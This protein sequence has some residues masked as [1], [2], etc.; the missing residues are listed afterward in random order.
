M[1]QICDFHDLKFTGDPFS[2]VGKRHTHDVACCLDRSLVNNEWLTQFPASHME[3]LELIESDHRPVITTI[4][5]DFEQKHNQFCFDGRMVERDGFSDAV[6]RGWDRRIFHQDDNLRSRLTACRREISQWKMRY[7]SNAQE[8]IALL[9]HRIDRAHSDG[10][11]TQHIRE[12]RLQLSKAYA[13][14]EDFWRLKSRKTWLSGGDR[15]TKYFFASAKTR[16]ARNRMYSILDDANVEH[17][18]SSNI[19]EVAQQF[20]TKLFQSDLT[21]NN[22]HY[23]VLNGFQQRVTSDMNAY[24]TKKITEE[25]VKEAVFSI[26]GTK[27]PGP[28]G[29]TGAFY[30]HYWEDIK[31]SIMAELLF[32]GRVITDNVIIAH[33][34][35]HA[36]KVKKRCSNLY[37]AI[38]TDITKAYDRLEWDFLQGAMFKFGFDVRWIEWIMTCVRTPTFSVNINGAPYGF[39]QP[40]RGIRQGYPLTSLYYVL[41]QSQSKDYLGWHY[42]DTGLYTVKSGYWLATHLHGDEPRALPPAGD[43]HLK[44]SIW[45]TT[46]APKIKHFLWKM[47]SKALA[48]GE[49]LERRHINPDKYCKRCFTETETTDH[50]FFTCPHA[51]QIWRASTIPIQDLTDSQVSLETKMTIIFEWHKQSSNNQLQAQLP[52]WI[53]R[54]IRK[55]RN[56]LIFGGEANTWEKDLSSAHHDAE[57]W[58]TLGDTRRLREFNSPIANGSRRILHWRRPEAGWIKCNYDGSYIQHLQ[59]TSGTWIIR[60]ELGHYK[61]AGKIQGTQATSALEAECNS[62]I[63]AMQHL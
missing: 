23:Y 13:A 27:A 62:L 46:T 15:N 5:S 34:V 17:R 55:S 50:L 39:I 11:T 63:S 7:R 44:R 21:T 49:E 33:E 54:R 1:I 56:K 20:F 32:Q 42:T 28:D 22:N 58:S 6:R 53:L 26:G 30:H 31:Q 43:P 25:E 3:F 18:G 48:T 8:D 19:G 16:S 37:M 59:R 45:K 47:L 24:L 2:W 52:F 29:F 51:M 36:L 60:N 14:E 9:K 35:I 61:G 38:K 40:E 12:L 4:T 41:S 10:T 57:E